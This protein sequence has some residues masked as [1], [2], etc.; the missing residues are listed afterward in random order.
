M[1]FFDVDELVAKWGRHFKP[2][3]LGPQ[4]VV[5]QIMTPEKTQLFFPL[6][7]TDSTVIDSALMRLGKV[8]QPFYAKFSHLGTLD[9]K[10]HDWNLDRVKINIEMTPDE[11]AETAADFWAPKR[12]EK[13]QADI[14]PLIVD[15]IIAQHKADNEED[16]IYK[17]VRKDVSP[18]DQLDRVAGVTVDSRTGIRHKIRLFNSLGIFS[19]LGSQ[20]AMGTVPTSPTA[21]VDY[22][23]TMFYSIPEKYRKNIKKIFMNTTYEKRFKDGMRAKYN[24]QYAQVGDL[25]YIIDTDVAIIGLESM[26]GSSHIWCTIEGNFRGHIKNDNRGIFKIEAFDTYNVRI[27]TDWYQGE[28]FYTPQFIFGNAQDLA[29]PTP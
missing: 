25:A 28:D 17:G 21:F 22:I 26:T 4:D 1:A 18:E 11:L 2:G 23:E 19:D 7:S 10:P 5:R 15:Y 13:L 6:R 27:S 16:I 3:G 24:S 29:L 14:V 8:T 20:I 12:P 9:F